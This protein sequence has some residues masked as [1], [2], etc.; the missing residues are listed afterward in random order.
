MLLRIFIRWPG[1]FPPRFFRL[2]ALLIDLLDRASGSAL[3]EGIVARWDSKQQNIGPLSVRP[4]KKTDEKGRK[5]TKIHGKDT[6][7]RRWVIG[8]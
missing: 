6:L 1:R 4:P 3:G 8:V 5:D 2:G 7:V